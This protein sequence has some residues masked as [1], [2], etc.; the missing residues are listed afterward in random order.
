VQLKPNLGILPEGQRILWPYLQEIPKNF[1]LYGGTAIALRYGHRQSIDFDFFTS[2]QGIDMQKIGEKLPFAGKFRYEVDRGSENHAD[3]HFSVDGHDVKLTLLNLEI[4]I[5]GS[6]KPPDI[7]EDNKI[8]I[9]TP[10]DLMA[11][12]MLAVQSRKEAK[13]FIDIAEMLKQGISMQQG[14]EAA[15]AVSRLSAHWTEKLRLDKIQDQFNDAM[16]VKQTVSRFPDAAIAA[17]AQEISVALYKAG[18][19]TSV[20]QAQRTAM[21]AGRT[22]ERDASQERDR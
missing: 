7:C 5:P 8:K 13:D 20:A 11:G 14:F 1:V 16:D 22:I 10:I 4:V 15:H 21:R 12:K 6:I 18:M 19:T 9:A 3:F 17:K 2:K